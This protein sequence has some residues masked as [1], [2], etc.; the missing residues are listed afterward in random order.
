MLQDWE[1]GKEVFRNLDAQYEWQDYKP[2]HQE[3]W[4]RGSHF[5]ARNGQ[6]LK[7][8]TF[9]KLGTLQTSFHDVRSLITKQLTF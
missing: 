2:T 7:K 3:Q 4:E 9:L 1:Q 8:V 5:S 6:S